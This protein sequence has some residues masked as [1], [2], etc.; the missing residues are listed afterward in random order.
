M[1]KLIRLVTGF[2]RHMS[3][4]NV[5]AY[6]SSA[7]FFIF[8][9]LIPII[10]LICT[11]LPFTP[12]QMTDLLEAVQVMP[13]PVV[14]IMEE[15]IKSLYQSSVGVMSFAAIMT[16]W[17]AGKGML[18]L[19]R[20]LNAMNGVVEDRNY[21]VQ[22]ILASV[23]TVIFLIILLLSLIVMVFGRTIVRVLSAHFPLLSHL[24]SLFETL[25]PLYSWGI[26]TIAFM[27]LYA[28]VPNCRLKLRDQFP[29]ALFS[30]VSWNLFS[31]VFSIYIENFNG[32][33]IYGSLST[34]VVLMLWMYFCMYLLLAGAHINRFAVPFK[35][36]IINK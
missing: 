22:R 36:E 8:L 27:F 7:A 32:M 21:V 31:Y 9:S 14:P 1:K 20:G 19:M 11:L 29:G 26:L 33:S 16:V 18:A 4:A 25:K 10:I 34:I 12:L 2:G 35:R 30:A 13:A 6:A 15:L 17:S 23:Y 28:F 5:S 24:I 3:K